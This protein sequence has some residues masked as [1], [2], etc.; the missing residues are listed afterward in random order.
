MLSVLVFALLGSFM[1]A[2]A[3]EEK[4]DK[5]HGDVFTAA[6]AQANLSDE[7]KEKI[8][9]INEESKAAMKAAREAK[10]KEAGKKAMA[11][12]REKVM[13]VLTAEQI[14]SV[15]KYMAEHRP[16]GDKKKKEKV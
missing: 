5:G 14:E 13:A 10:D 12:H 4:K 6:L 2:N 8:K 7:Q 16:E 9:T 1:V 3:A 15:K 11:D